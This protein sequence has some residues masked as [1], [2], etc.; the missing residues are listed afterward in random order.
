M[1]KMGFECLEL[2]GIIEMPLTQFYGWWYHSHVEI[3]KVLD[4]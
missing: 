2:K 3:S 1:K 4:E